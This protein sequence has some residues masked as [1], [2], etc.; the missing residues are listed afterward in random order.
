ML[1]HRAPWSDQ[2]GTWG[3]P[4]GAIAPDETPAQ[5]ALREAHEEAGIDPGA[6]RVLT[7]RTLE[8]GPWRYTT[9]V[10]EVVAGAE[11]TP[12]ATDAESLEVVWVAVEDVATLDL[13]PA[14]AEAWPALRELLG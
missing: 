3:V 6:V 4:G 5:G 12:A 9:V 10:A 8:H 7:Q 2:G 14:F 13:L 11:V 1:Q